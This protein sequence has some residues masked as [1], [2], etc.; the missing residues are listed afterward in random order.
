MSKGKIKDVGGFVGGFLV[1]GRRNPDKVLYRQLLTLDL[2]FAHKD[3][4]DDF[5]MLFNCAAFLHATHKHSDV[6]PALS[7]TNTFIS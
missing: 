3:F 4:W 2:D 5:T 6:N 1:G 7:F